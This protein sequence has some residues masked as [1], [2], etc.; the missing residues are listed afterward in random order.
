M[1]V[2]PPLDWRVV[3]IV[4]CKSSGCCELLGALGKGTRRR[5]ESPEQLTLRFSRKLAGLGAAK[6][7]SYIL[8]CW[9]EQN[10]LW[11]QIRGPDQHKGERL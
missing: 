7:A 3:G 2:Q 9:G 10:Q 8:T 6:D 11:F 4:L 1:Q 5:Q